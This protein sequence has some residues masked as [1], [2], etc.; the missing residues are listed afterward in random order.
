MVRG[1]VMWGFLYVCGTSRWM[2]MLIS[3]RGGSGRRSE[4]YISRWDLAGREWRLSSYTMSIKSGKSYFDIMLCSQSQG[5]DSRATV[6]F[7]TGTWLAFTHPSGSSL[8]CSPFAQTARNLLRR[9]R[10]ISW[11]EMLQVQWHTLSLIKYLLRLS[12]NRRSLISIFRNLTHHLRTGF[13]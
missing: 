4:L 8:S 5:I 11:Q 10:R 1:M 6:G 7:M 2:V 9:A 13:A 3:E 12:H